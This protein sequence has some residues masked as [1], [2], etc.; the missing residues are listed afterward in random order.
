MKF[1]LYKSNKPDKK[2]MVVTES[3]KHIHFGAKGNKDYIYYNTIDKQL[4]LKKKKAYIA[5]HKVNENWFDSNTAGFWSKWI[6]WYKPTL[7]QSIKSTE[8]KFKIKI[9]NCT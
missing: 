6:L 7:L 5:R 4:A 8:K 1:K 9:I 2:Y 3:G